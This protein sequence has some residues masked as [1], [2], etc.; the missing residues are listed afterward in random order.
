MLQRSQRSVKQPVNILS[1]VSLRARILT[2]YCGSIKYLELLLL[3]I[4]KIC[5]HVC[6]DHTGMCDVCGSLTRESSAD[7][8]ELERSFLTP[9]RQPLFCFHLW[10][11]GSS[12]LS[13]DF[14]GRESR[15]LICT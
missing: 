11:H 15:N 9:N 6:K 5:V 4:A 3:S 8:G 10:E 1:L 2:Q 13:F 14:S 12:V 7:Y